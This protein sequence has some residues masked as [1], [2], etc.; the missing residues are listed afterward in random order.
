MQSHEPVKTVIFVSARRP[1]AAME[2][3]ID[4]RGI[5]VQW[6]NSIQAAGD[7]L[8]SAFDGTVLVTELALG[9]GNWRDLVEHVRSVRS[10]VR[11]VLMASASTAELWWDALECG[12][13]DILVSP[14][15][16]NTFTI[17]DCKIQCKIRGSLFSVS[18]PEFRCLGL[19]GGCRSAKHGRGV[20]SAAHPPVLL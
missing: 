20:I 14:S 4:A 7:L 13:E 17:L 5:R 10:P 15:P 19:E 2:L 6:A 8:N 3:E 18:T 11:I 1:E 9:E 16:E 12:V